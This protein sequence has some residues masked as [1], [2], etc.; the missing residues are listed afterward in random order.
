M[1]LDPISY[2]FTVIHALV[3]DEKRRG[4]RAHGARVSCSVPGFLLGRLMTALRSKFT[5][6]PR[7]EWRP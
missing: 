4:E 7:L 2:G 6:R 3:L 5:V 1:F